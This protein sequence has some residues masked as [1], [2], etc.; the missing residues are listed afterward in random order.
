MHIPQ[1][2]YSIAFLLLCM[3]GWLHCVYIPESLSK[4]ISMAT[5]AIMMLFYFFM[6][7]SVN[8]I[9]RIV[10]L[11]VIPLLL[12]H[13]SALFF[14]DQNVFLTWRIAYPWFGICLCLFFFYKHYTEDEIYKGIMIFGGI[15]IIAYIVSVIKFPDSIFINPYEDSDELTQRGWYRIYIEGSAVNFFLFYWNLQKYI[16]NKKIVYLI[17]TTLFLL[18]IFTTLSRQHILLTSIMFL[19]IIIKDLSW[20]RKVILIALFSLFAFYY[21]P[22]TEIYENMVLLSETQINRNESED[23][24]RIQAYQYYLNYN[25]ND[26]GQILFGNGFYHSESAYGREIRMIMNKT[27]CILADVGGVAIYFYF[28]IVGYIIMIF[29]FLKMFNYNKNE[30]MKFIN[31]YL[32]AILLGTIFS[33][34]LNGSMAYISIAL[35]LLTIQCNKRFNTI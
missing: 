25:K 13:I 29:A 21:I 10:R 31:Y 18:A 17:F 15:W 24:I 26:V 19:L 22:K 12:C 34:Q 20:L 11:F 9:M 8:G 33:N 35:Y 7:R 1:R 4:L 28:G 3:H 14:H 6:I 2:S 27:Q 23:D 5:I 32:L 16:V 30:E